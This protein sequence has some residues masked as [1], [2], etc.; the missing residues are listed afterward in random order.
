LRTVVVLHYFDDLPLSEIGKVLSVP[1][2]TVK[3]RLHHAESACKRLFARK[4]VV[5]FIA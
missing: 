5:R 3:F 4:S 2:G 1:L